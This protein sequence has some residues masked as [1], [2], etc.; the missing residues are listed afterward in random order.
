MSAARIDET[1]DPTLRSWVES[2]N[3]PATDFPIQNLPFGRFRRAASEPWQ[4]RRRDR[5]PGAGPAAAAGFDRR[6]GHA[7]ADGV[8]PGRT[9]A[10]APRAV[11]AR[12]ARTA[13]A[14]SSCS[15]CCSR[16]RRWSSG[17]RARSATTP[18]STPA[19]TTR[20]R[21]ASSSVPTTR[22]CPTTSG[23]RSAITGARRRLRASG[24]TLPPSARAGR[25]RPSGTDAELRRRRAGSTTSW[26]SGIFIA[27]AQ[28]AG[29]AGARSA[30]RRGASVRPHAVQRLE[31]ARHAGVGIPAA[32][33]V[34]VEELRQ[35]GVALDRDAG[36]AGAVSRSRSY[37]PAGDPDSAAVPRL[38]R[39]PRGRRHRHRSS[40]SGCRRRA[41]REAGACAAADQPLEL[42]EQPTG[43]V[44]QLVAHHTVNGC[45]L[46]S[47]DLFGI[48]HAVRAA[49]GP[50]RLD[51]RAEPRRPASR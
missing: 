39:Q 40:K 29:R 48:G 23:C 1:H 8:E 31:R 22:C 10:T 50:R 41:M 37:A 3:D 12:C 45:N 28:R 26:S 13:R 49:G 4:H 24:H 30:G 15:R 11:R 18:T 25:R 36:G 27:S 35:H 47:G 17:C 20:R 14:A 34:P 5:R 38:D 2:A 32:R 21:S 6:R 33:A 19:S 46:R 43:R 44:A 16:S 42:P 51:A 9:R 7:T